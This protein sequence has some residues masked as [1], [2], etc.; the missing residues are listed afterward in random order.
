[1]LFSANHFAFPPVVKVRAVL[2]TADPRVE[3]VVEGARAGIGVGAGVGVGAGIGVE[4]WE[5]VVDN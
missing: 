3:V 4:D 1:M 5:P 2:S